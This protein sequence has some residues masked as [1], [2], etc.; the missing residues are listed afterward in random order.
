MTGS[1]IKMEQDSD[2]EQQL[3]RQQYHQ[4]AG[5]NIPNG[6]HE[7]TASSDV[8]V[9]R[10]EN[11]RLLTTLLEYKKMLENTKLRYGTMKR[12]FYAAK[13]RM[14]RM[15]NKLQL[16]GG[17]SGTVNSRD[18]SDSGDSNLNPANSGAGGT[19]VDDEI[20]KK[21]KEPNLKAAVKLKAAVGMQAYRYLIRDGEL[22]LPSL[23]TISRYVDALKKV[24][25]KPN[26]DFNVRDDDSVGGTIFEELNEDSGDVDHNRNQH[27]PNSGSGK[28]NSQQTSRDVSDSEEPVN[29][30]EMKFRELRT[31]EIF[32]NI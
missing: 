29:F 30:T 26:Y 19:Q 21:W 10:D 16:T 23:R 31:I 5:G 28:S 12:E 1:P 11:C 13:K 6:V 25:M 17:G 20:R 18:G 24:G 3:L 27:H 14:K 9:L 15:A 4:P 22:Q 8:S 7:L 2:H 32:R